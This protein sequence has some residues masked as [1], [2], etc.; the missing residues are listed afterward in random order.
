MKYS[1]TL[2]EEARNW[3]IEC[4]PDDEG[5]IEITSDREIMECIARD[6]DGGIKDF[7]YE[8]EG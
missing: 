2:I 3:L 7:I 5:I 1:K 8:S 4:Y 6:Y